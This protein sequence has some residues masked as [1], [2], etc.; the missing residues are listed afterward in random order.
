MSEPPIPGE[1][2]QKSPTNFNTIL[3]DAS[4]CAKG[5][6]FCVASSSCQ[7]DL[8]KAENKHVFFLMVYQPSWVI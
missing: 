3:N 2:C 4:M 8:V 1:E 5:L 7:E 6:G